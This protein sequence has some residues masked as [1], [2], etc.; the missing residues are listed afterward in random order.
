MTEHLTLELTPVFRHSSLYNNIKVKEITSHFSNFRQ[1][2]LVIFLTL[3]KFKVFATVFLLTLG[4]S[5][6][7]Q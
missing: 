3:G 4:K 5:I 2:I 1:A 6:L 7:Q